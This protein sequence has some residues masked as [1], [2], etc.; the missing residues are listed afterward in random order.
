MI[1][2]KLGLVYTDR[3]HEMR[4]PQIRFV[5]TNSQL[6]STALRNYSEIKTIGATF[7]YSQ[8]QSFIFDNCERRRAKRF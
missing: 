2:E 8:L 5:F 6:M 1:D 7:F 3:K 4:K